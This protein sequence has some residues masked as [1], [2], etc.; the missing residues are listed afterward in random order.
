MRIILLGPPGAGKGTQAQQICEY[1]QIPLISTGDILRTAIKNGTE[2]GL[3]AKKIIDA[4]ELVSDDIIMGLVKSRLEYPDCDNGY[5]LDGVPRTIG[6]AEAIDNLGIKIDFV[7]ELKVDEN[8]IL[9]RIT[10]RR[11]HQ[12]SGRNYHVK[13]NPPKL[14][15]KDDITGEDLIQR[16]DD[17]ED[18]VKNRLKVYRDETLPLVNFYKDKENI[19]YFEINGVGEVSEVTKRIFSVLQAT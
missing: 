5:L 11:V 10:G 17:K 2:L 13:F 7:V 8:L 3:K 18:T 12:A 9:E 15:N 16:P 4:G 19:K 1:Y 6:Q 14:A